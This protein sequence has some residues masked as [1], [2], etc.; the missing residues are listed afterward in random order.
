MK[1]RSVLSL[2]VALVMAIQVLPLS[3]FAGDAEE[4][5]EIY[6]I[7]ETVE[8]DS[9]SLADND[10]LLE[11]YVS[12]LLGFSDN[13][14]IMLTATYTGEDALS[15]VNYDIYSALKTAIAKIASGETSSSVI[16]LAVTYDASYFGASTGSEAWTAFQYAF[17]SNTVLYYLL[18]DC[19]YELYWFDK[20][21][22]CTTNI[23]GGAYSTYIALTLTF[24]FCVSVDYQLDGSETTVNSSKVEA[25]KTAAAAAQTIVDKYAGYSDIE[26]LTAYK[27][28]ICAL[29]SYD[30]TTDDDTDYGD[31]WQ[32]VYVFD[33]DESTDVVCEGYSK[34]FQYLCDLD[35]GLD[36]ITV[37]G[38]MQGATGAGAHMWN[39]VY[40]DG[41]N[42]LVDVTNSDSGSAGQDGELFMVCADDAY[43]TDYNGWDYIFYA[44]NQ[45]IYYIYDS[46]T[47]AL[48]P[49]DYLTLGTRFYGRALTL[50]GEIGV[51]YYFVMS[52]VTNPDEY[53]LV[54]TVGGTS[55]DTVTAETKTI[56]GVT[57][58]RYTV[59][60]SPTDVSS[61][62][63]ATLTDGTNEID[64]GTF[65]AYDYCEY[66]L[67]TDGWEDERALCEAVLNYAYYAQ[68]Y[69]GGESSLQDSIASLDA[70]WTDPVAAWD[71]T[72]S[73]VCESDGISKSLALNR[74][75]I[76]VVVYVGDNTSTY[77]VDGETLEV[78]TDST[79]YYVEFK[80]PARKM[81]T[82]YTV[83]KD[84][85]A[86]TTYSVYTYVAH[87]VET[88]VSSEYNITQEAVDLCKAIYYYGVEAAAY[89]N[90]Q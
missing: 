49:E 47:T 19:P 76:Y 9:S 35:G 77:T 36:C 85:E 32:L 16:D 2:V 73:N 37:T 39:I 5:T 58:Y 42:Y 67:T 82:A 69:V 20:D 27:D 59:Y 66:A 8:V 78:N 21:T 88:G 24:S 33:G 40:M 18:S 68:L 50:D 11:S 23:S 3:L 7:T 1:L 61:E 43:A 29:V 38:Y 86:Y 70:D 44:G 71:E 81:G 90:W 6:S 34:A 28:E 14:G 12:E 75:G 30:D 10:E 53:S 79:G 54:A 65:S 15:G 84:G 25:A 89:G 22:G 62:I 87:I 57:Y 46:N 52:G 56:S 45:Y 60:V 72:I 26:R 74:D 41:I 51:T 63:V 13:S 4:A 83:Y 80:V 17:S 64:A 55:A 48:Y 31:I